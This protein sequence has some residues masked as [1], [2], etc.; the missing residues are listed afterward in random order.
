MIRIRTVA[1]LFFLASSLLAIKSVDSC[2][3][4]AD[5]GETYVLSQPVL[6]K[7]S[8]F[9]I[10]APNITLDCAG[11]SIT[12][13][14]AQ[15]SEGIVAKAPGAVIKNCQIS[16]FSKAIHF[17]GVSGGKIIQVNAAST[18][19]GIAIYLES[20]SQNIISDSTAFAKK[21]AMS[22]SENGGAGQVQA[23]AGEGGGQEVGIR[24]FSSSGNVLENVS[25][26]SDEYVGLL[27]HSN[28]NKNIF[29]NVRAFSSSGKEACVG[30]PCGAIH[31]G[32]ASGNSFNSV[33][34]QATQGYA[35]RIGMGNNNSFSDS[36]FTTEDGV[37]VYMM[38][39]DSNKI[40][41]SDIESL[42]KESAL[43]QGSLGNT[44]SGNRLYSSSNPPVLMDADSTDNSISQNTVHTPGSRKDAAPN[45]EFTH[46][47][48]PEGASDGLVPLFA[49]AALAAVSLA[50]YFIF[51]R[52]KKAQQ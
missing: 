35:L 9:A 50:G 12:G 20:S 17:K 13:G 42:S 32:Q 10:G 16:G 41:G 51:F 1:I 39:S 34:A 27:V 22:G 2:A 48:K 18:N 6:G 46:G 31:L 44:I 38:D 11:F 33:S 8:C 26:S 49:L 7:G 21:K 4:L 45:N 43:L 30:G 23:G 24:L 28:S 14:D 25:A 47:G 37:S 5:A 52:K 40:T 29:K 15:G 19:G 3:T 36:T